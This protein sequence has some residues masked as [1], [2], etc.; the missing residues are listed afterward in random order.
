MLG[1]ARLQTFQV[2]NYYLGKFP[3]LKSKLWLATKRKI[4]KESN[5]LLEKSAA[6]QAL[7]PLLTRRDCTKGAPFLPAVI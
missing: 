4:S 2:T 1:P 5:L 3:S 6:E 7:S